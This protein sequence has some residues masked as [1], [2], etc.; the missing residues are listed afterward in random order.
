MFVQSLEH[1][2]QFRIP[3]H[4]A[5]S[6]RPAT[7]LVIVAFCALGIALALTAMRPGVASAAA[8][9][10]CGGAVHN[11]DANG[12]G[13]HTS[14][15]ILQTW[16]AERDGGLQAVIRIKTAIWGPEHFDEEVTGAG[17]AV[18][19]EVAGTTRFVR[20]FASGSE[21]IRYDHGTWTLAGNFVSLG[22]T[23]GSTETGAGGTV[24]IEV[25]ATTGAVPGVVL[26]RTFALTYDGASIAGDPHW[27][28]RAPGGEDPAGTA[29]GADFLVGSCAAATGGPGGD[30]GGDT[31]GGAVDPA[32]RTTAVQINAPARLKGGGAAAVTGRVLPARGGVWVTV[33]RTTARSTIRTRLRTRPDGSYRLVLPIREHTG[34]RATA[35]G[36]SSQTRTISVA[37]TVRIFV[38]RLRTGRTVIV[39]RVRPAIPGEVQLLEA[40]DFAPTATRTTFGN[41]FIISLR[42]IPAGRYDV[43]F[44]P[45]DDRAERSTSNRVVVR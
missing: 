43:V 27:V 13:H 26:T 32:A 33:A 21:P 7:H 18:L 6:V 44:I 42:S 5:V 2:M 3:R 31:N 45:K 25:P 9:E 20:A 28:D 14:T 35:E 11:T 39:G 22:T 41:R 17:F 38:H 23:T 36:L 19:F 10:P 29:F 12:D 1:S 8:P 16:W 40:D 24:T 4:V 34:V 15:D 30:P 37:S